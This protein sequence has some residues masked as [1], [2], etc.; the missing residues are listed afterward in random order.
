MHYN[1]GEYDPQLGTTKILH[2]NISLERLQY[3]YRGYNLQL[4]VGIH[5]TDVYGETRHTAYKSEWVFRPRTFRVIEAET[6]RILNPKEVEELLKKS[7][8]SYTEW[9]WWQKRYLSWKKQNGF[10]FRRTPVPGQGRWPFFRGHAAKHTNRKI[11]LEPMIRPKLKNEV[12]RRLASY[13]YDHYSNERSW[14]AHRKHQ[15]K[16]KK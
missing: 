10:E 11:L 14:K 7:T 6:K 12:R 15:W 4:Y 16:E 1:V 2:K 9:P 3:V 13:D 8:G 5:P